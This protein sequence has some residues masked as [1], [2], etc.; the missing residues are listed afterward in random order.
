[1]KYIAQYIK[2]LC[3]DVSV[4][5]SETSDSTYYRMTR[6]LTIRLSDHIGHKDKNIIS[7]V[8]SFNTDNF[9]VMYNGSPFPFVKERKEVNEMI[10]TVYEMAVVNERTEKY[11]SDKKKDEIE[12]LTDWGDLFG[13]IC[14]MIPHACYLSKEQRNKLKECFNDG[15]KT[16]KIIAAISKIKPSTTL[17][18]TVEIIDEMSSVDFGTTP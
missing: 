16:E 1:M 18:R 13:R 11:D 9:I 6:K 12:A 2:K 7:V 10:R 15:M 17:E 4:K 8:K 14:S 3:P 5:H